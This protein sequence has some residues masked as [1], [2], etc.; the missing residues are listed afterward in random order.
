LILKFGLLLELEKFE[1]ELLFKF[2]ILVL[3]EDE[4]LTAPYILEEDPEIP[5]FNISVLKKF[6]SLLYKVER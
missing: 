4:T 1:P 6:N 2:P 3:N 5:I